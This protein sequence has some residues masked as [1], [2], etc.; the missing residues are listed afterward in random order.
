[1]TE[2]VLISIQAW[3]ILDSNS[4]YP[5]ASRLFGLQF[6]ACVLSWVMMCRRVDGYNPLG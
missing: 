1:M 4:F 6:R 3:Q 2:I 5:V